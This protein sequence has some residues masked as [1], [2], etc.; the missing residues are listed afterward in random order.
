MRSLLTVTA[1]LWSLVAGTILGDLAI[2]A[3]H[4]TRLCPCGARK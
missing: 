4:R 2:D 1:L 3:L